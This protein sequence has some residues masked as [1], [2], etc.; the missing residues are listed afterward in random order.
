MSGSAAIASSSAV[1][2]AARS[3][4][5][6]GSAI[7]AMA[8]ARPESGNAITRNA[9]AVGAAGRSSTGRGRSS[10]RSRPT[11]RCTGWSG[12]HITG[13]GSPRCRSVARN[14]R[15]CPSSCCAG[16]R[17]RAGTNERPRGVGSIGGCAPQSRSPRRAR[18]AR[19]RPR[20]PRHAAPRH[21]A[22]R[23]RAR[24]RWRNGQRSAAP[25][26]MSG[27]A[28]SGFTA[29]RASTGRSISPH[30]ITMRPSPHRPRPRRRGAGSRRSRRASL[31]QDGARGGLA[32]PR[33]LALAGTAPQAST[34]CILTTLGYGFVPWQDRTALALALIIACGIGPAGPQGAA[35]TP[36]AIGG[37]KGWDAY[38][39]TE[40]AGKVCYLVG[41]PSKSEPRHADARPH[42][43]ARHPPAQGERASTSS[44][45]TW[46]MPSRPAPA[47]SSTSTATNSRS[48]PTRTRPGRATPPTDKAVTEALAKGKRAI[49][50]GTSAR[51]TAT[52]DTYALDGFA[53]A[54]AAIDKACRGVRQAVG[55]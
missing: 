25:L 41:H 3:G 11:R 46:A 49:L 54:L 5:S 31:R 29:E 2:A 44:I 22:S 55:R 12:V 13:V 26:S 21:G 15:A 38:S 6:P 4:G 20:P 18:C 43:R 35:A 39:Y 14:P 8:R 24:V 1:A 10:P 51:G 27:S 47:P 19:A 23:R 32:I 30:A 9:A 40:K 16:P 28:C 52:T 7:R 53:E 42:R 48:S 36:T 17:R 33:T 37:D 45:S 50:K 34:L